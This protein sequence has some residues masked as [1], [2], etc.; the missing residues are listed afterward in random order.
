MALG[1]AAEFARE[2]LPEGSTPR[3]DVEDIIT[4][5]DDAAALVR[6]LLAFSRQ[7]ALHRKPLDLNERLRGLLKMLRRLI[8]ED[9]ELVFEPPWNHMMMSEAARLETGM[10]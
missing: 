8:G 5:A 9:V 7:Q 10:F 3:Q 2:A 4:L 1:G 6:Q